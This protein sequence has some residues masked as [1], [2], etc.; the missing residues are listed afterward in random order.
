[1]PVVTATW[2]ALGSPKRALPL[3][4]LL[5]GLVTAEW[6]ATESGAALAIDVGLFLAFCLAA[7]AGY[8]LLTHN[9]ASRALGHALYVLLCAAIVVGGVLLLRF[10]LG[11]G[12]TYV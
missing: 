5:V 4:L 9:T 3:G 2:R 10:G 7:P 12:W 6:L 1:M 8:R 11:L